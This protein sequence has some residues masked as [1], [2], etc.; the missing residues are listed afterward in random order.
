MRR[1]T[2]SSDTVEERV[3]RTVQAYLT[4]GRA[5]R[6]SVEVLTS[7]NTRSLARARASGLLGLLEHTDVAVLPCS[8]FND[9]ADVTLTS[10]AYQRIQAASEAQTHCKLVLACVTQ[11]TGTSPVCHRKTGCT[12][13]MCLANP[14]Q[15]VAV[16]MMLVQRVPAH[17]AASHERRL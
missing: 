6:D 12:V 10:A 1:L 15:P 7:L 8:D 11:D 5:R 2:R 3:L 17:G 14:M 16:H 13:Y 4:S 9:A